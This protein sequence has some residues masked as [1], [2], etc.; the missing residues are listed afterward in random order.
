MT[1][2]EQI[3]I[4]LHVLRLLMDRAFKQNNLLLPS[5][6]YTIHRLSF[7]TD[8]N[9]NPSQ[10]WILIKP[11]IIILFAQVKRAI[12]IPAIKIDK[13]NFMEKTQDQRLGER[14]SGPG[15]DLIAI[16]QEFSISTTNWAWSQ[17]K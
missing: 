14:F 3:G 8:L 1:K 10:I 15:F 4:L 2:K 9:P 11:F 6:F 5:I 13:G 16:F 12:Q 7:I 17:G